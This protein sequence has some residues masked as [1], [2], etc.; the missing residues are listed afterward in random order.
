M[1]LVHFDRFG[2]GPA[3]AVRRPGLAALLALPVLGYVLSEALV[4]FLSGWLK[5]ESGVPLCGAGPGKGVRD[6]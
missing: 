2:A 3:W 4:D 1:N 6:G 5:H